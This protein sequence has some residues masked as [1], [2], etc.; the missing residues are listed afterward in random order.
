MHRGHLPHGAA[1]DVGPGPARPGR[2]AQPEEDSKGRRVARQFPVP[3][4]ELSNVVTAP[5]G[6]V[7]VDF[8][9]GRLSGGLT[10]DAVKSRAE[11]FSLGN[12]SVWLASFDDVIASKRAADR[13]KDR[14]HLE[15]IRQLLIVREAFDEWLATDPPEMR[16]PP[17]PST[18]DGPVREAAPPRRPRPRRRAPAAAPRPPRASAASRGRP[19]PPRR[20]RRKASAPR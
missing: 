9:F 6:P 7:P 10:F 17:L 16:E 20:P 12:V 8:T 2:A 14:D 18:S 4:S 15:I 3:S 13:P 1:A 11:R 19:A 5:D